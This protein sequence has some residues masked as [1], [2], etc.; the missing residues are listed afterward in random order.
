MTNYDKNN[1][2]T[3]ALVWLAL[4]LIPYVLVLALIVGVGWGFLNIFSFST[5]NNN[6]FQQY[7]NNI[8]H[9]NWDKNHYLLHSKKVYTEKIPIKE[10]KKT[11]PIIILGKGRV[12]EHQGYINDDTITW[13]AVR[14]YIK[15]QETFGYIFSA[16]N[17]A[18][19]KEVSGKFED[20]FDKK[21]YQKYKNM[22][23]QKIKVKKIVGAV[24]IKEYEENDKYDEID[25]LKSGKN[26]RCFCKVEKDCDLADKIYDF[27][28]DSTHQDIRKY[29]ANSRFILKPAFAKE[30]K[31]N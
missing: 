10:I 1:L 30:S 2:V 6:G 15:D 16:K 4:K 31:N 19:S 14:F 9:F 28:D 21:T 27:W 13:T 5:I 22:L 24:K 17:K 20:N 25:D 18:I 3:A 11:K 29:Q 26:T 8:I 23:Y 7:Y 12:F